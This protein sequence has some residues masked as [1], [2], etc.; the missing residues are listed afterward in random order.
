VSSAQLIE[1]EK[2]RE[3]GIEQLGEDKDNSLVTTGLTGRSDRSCPG[4]NEDACLGSNVA[5]DAIIKTLI[6]F[7]S[8][9]RDREDAHNS[10]PE[11]GSFVHGR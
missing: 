11:N 9:G 4:K 7:K 1:L 5:P 10:L 3:W 6:M 2:R 8:W